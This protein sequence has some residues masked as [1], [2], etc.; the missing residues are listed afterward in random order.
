[1]R[2]LANTVI[3]V[4]TIVA[5]CVLAQGYT[6]QKPSVRRFGAVTELRADKV[7][8]YKKLH[9]N[10]WPG[11]L[12]MIRKG[13]IRNYS[14][15][16]KE[17]EPGRFY[18]FSYFEYVGSD[19]KGDMKKMAADPTTRK[20]WKCTDPCQKPLPTRAKGEKNWSVMEE[21]FHTDGGFRLRTEKR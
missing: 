19:F 6:N 10:V 8:E 16:L 17:I 2:M 7:A 20:W 12:K 11:V 4:V 13:N 1:M 5:L 18:L 9:A 3:L 15:Y 21:V 14:I